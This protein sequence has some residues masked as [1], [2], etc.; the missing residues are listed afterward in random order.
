MNPKPFAQPSW[1][2]F[3]GDR[4]FRLLHHNPD[5]AQFELIGFENKI[6]LLDYRPKTL[7]TLEKILAHKE[8]VNTFPSAFNTPAFVDIKDLQ[9]SALEITLTATDEPHPSYML[10]AVIGLD[11]GVPIFDYVATRYAPLDETNVAFFSLY[12]R[13]QPLQNHQQLTSQVTHTDRKKEH[14]LPSNELSW[15]AISTD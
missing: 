7:K 12:Q 11:D 14:Y 9:S 6:T 4:V 10:W 2:S 8:N 1:I 5:Y 3:Q 13:P 15:L